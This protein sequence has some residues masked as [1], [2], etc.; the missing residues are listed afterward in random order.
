[1][2]INQSGEEDAIEPTQEV[3]KEAVRKDEGDLLAAVR[4]QI[5]GVQNGG[6]SYGNI[7]FSRLINEAG[8]QVTKGR[9]T[10]QP[11]KL[12]NTE[13]STTRKTEFLSTLRDFPKRKL[14]MKRRSPR[15]RWR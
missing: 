1:M 10:T 11:S 4:E 14:K 6:L 9:G 7:L 5:R 2:R 15:E 12:P 13:N 3:I 8:I